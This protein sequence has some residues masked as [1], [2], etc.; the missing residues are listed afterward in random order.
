MVF[1]SIYVG[2]LIHPNGK[3][4]KVDSIK[5]VAEGATFNGTYYG[6]SSGSGCVIGDITNTLKD[7]TCN[8]TTNK[9]LYM[10][11]GN[12]AKSIGI[13][14]NELTNVDAGKCYIYGGGSGVHTMP[15]NAEY[16]MV[17]TVD[18]GEYSGV[19]GVGGGDGAVLNGNSKLTIKSGIFNGYS[20]ASVSFPYAVMGAGRNAQVNGNCVTEIYGGTFNALT[21]AGTAAAGSSNAKPVNGNVTLYIYGGEFYGKVNANGAFIQEGIVASGE[22]KVIFNAQDAIKI[23]KN[24]NIV[25]EEVIGTLKVEQT[26]GWLAHDY[27]VLPAGAQYQ[28]TESPAIFGSYVADDTIL[29]KGAAVSPVGATIRLA[30]RL[31]VRIVLNKND[32]EA[33][34]EEFTYTVKLGDTTVATGTYADI[35]ANN[36]SILFDGIG[37]SQFGDTFTVICP[38]M[39]DISYSIVDLAVMAQTAWAEKAEWKAYAD[40]IIEFHNVYNLDQANTMTPAAVALVPTAAK[41][42]LG[43][44]IVAGKAKVTLLMSDAAGVRVTVEL[45]AAPESAKIVVAD[46]EFAA[47]IEGNTLTADVFFAHEALADEFTFSVQNGEGKA[48]MTCTSSIEALANL[49]ANDDANENKDNATAFLVYVQKAVACK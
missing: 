9:S 29:V 34:G 21:T 46:K 10:G 41:G 8:Q 11:G 24:T 17:T 6:G 19:W 28:I 36:Y 1:E 38:P 5:T 13:I 32:V 23:G 43:D 20:D 4:S 45:A 30:E 42:E 14:T 22:A 7:L 2:G 18:G 33:Y 31:G 25:A 47:T 16:A 37:L 12:K 27:I 49:L 26:E 35:V 48:Y 15:E 44:E 39:A 40:A 3:Y